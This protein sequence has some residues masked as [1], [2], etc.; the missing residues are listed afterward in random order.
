MGSTHRFPIDDAFSRALLYVVQ[1]LGEVGVT[2]LEKILYLADLEHFHRTGQTITG[3]NWVRYKLGPLAKKLIPARNEMNG[4]EI[5][6][7]AEQW[8]GREAQVFRPG[9][10]PRF[11]PQLA[12]DKRR[13]LDRIIEMLRSASADDAIRLAY[14]TSPMEFLQAME[15]GRP[16]YN[17]RIPFELEGRVIAGVAAPNRPKVQG[18]REFKLEE[19]AR[20][21][22]LQEAGLRVAANAARQSS[23]TP[24]P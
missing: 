19:L 24:S 18:R 11:A 20:I 8:G 9:R 5:S 16:R 6:V 17:V 21:S 3:A 15:H 13:D 10:Q 23:D 2:K 7:S 12:E 1:S 22:D 14:R 4:H